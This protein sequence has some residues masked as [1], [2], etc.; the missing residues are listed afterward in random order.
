MCARRKNCITAYT[1]GEFI[2]GGQ[3]L[4]PQRHREVSWDRAHRPYHG[5]VISVPLWFFYP[6]CLVPALDGSDRD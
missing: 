2:S 3:N 4:K 1:R 5:K 6:G